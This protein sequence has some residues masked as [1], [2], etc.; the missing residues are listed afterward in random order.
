[1][2][3]CLSLGLFQM[4]RKI[5]DAFVSTFYILGLWVRVVKENPSICLGCSPITILNKRNNENCLVQASYLGLFAYS[6]LNLIPTDTP[7]LNFSVPFLPIH[8]GE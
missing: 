2:G 8:T 4:L 7:M 1:M 5:M 6:Q 3:I